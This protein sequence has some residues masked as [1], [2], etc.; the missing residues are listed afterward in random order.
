MATPY[1]ENHQSGMNCLLKH[2]FNRIGPF[3]IKYFFF[4]KNRISSKEILQ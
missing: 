2:Y 4:K 1:K 3:G